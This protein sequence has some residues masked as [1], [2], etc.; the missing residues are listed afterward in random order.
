MALTVKLWGSTKA[1]EPERSLWQKTKSTMFRLLLSKSLIA[2]P[3]TRS[4]V[5]YA[6]PGATLRQGGVSPIQEADTRGPVAMNNGTR[7]TIT[8]VCYSAGPGLRFIQVP[9]P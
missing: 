8:L 2:M 1:L 3:P 9:T 7:M 6:V 5:K 4:I